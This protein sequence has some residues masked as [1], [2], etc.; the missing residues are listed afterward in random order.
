M[1][2][3]EQS[4]FF[5][6]RKALGTD[7]PKFAFPLLTKEEWEDLYN[8]AKK[9]TLTGVL[10]SGIQ[11]LDPDLA[12]PKKILLQWFA[13]VEKIKERNIQLNKTVV[14]VSERFAVD[15][16]KSAILKG[17]GVALYYPEPLLRMPGDIDIWLDGNREDIIKYVRKYCPKEGARYHHIDF[18]VMKNVSIEVHFTPTWMN[19]FSKNKLLQGLFEDWKET[20]FNNKV[21]LDDKDVKGF[22]VPT[23][24]MNRIFLLI[25]IYHHFFDE[26][27]GLRQLV[28]YFYLLR[29]G[30][31]DEEKK[32]IQQI[33]QSLGIVKFT[34]AL[35]YVM[36]Q[37][38]GLPK[39]CLLTE[40]NEKDGHFVLKEILIS[41]NFGHDDERIYRKNGKSTAF[42]WSKFTHKAHFVSAYPKDIYHN[43]SF[44]V[45]Q[46]FWRMKNGYL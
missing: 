14:K 22:C 12:P 10:L 8:L 46:Y 16:F 4:F 13:Q 26:G 25:H 32:E 43:I 45:W 38:M 41:G 36:H 34:K 7:S 23:D 42:Y 44:W 1:G 28:D 3:I 21:N 27:I 30:C 19:A 17:Q 24:K 40:P 37:I 5:L 31:S 35:M 6:L 20:T 18:P 2:K 33:I 11:K 29:R 9:Q 39:E 15:G